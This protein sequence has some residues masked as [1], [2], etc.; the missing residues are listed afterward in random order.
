MSVL[1]DGFFISRPAPGA[2]EFRGGRHGETS[3]PF[4]VSPRRTRRRHGV[5]GGKKTDG[6]AFL[7]VLREIVSVLSVVKQ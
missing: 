4:T 1:R 6:V 5:H 3:Y 2:T 7:R